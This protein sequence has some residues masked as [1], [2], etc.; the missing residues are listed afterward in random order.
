MILT[1]VEGPIEDNNYLIFNEDTKN[2]ILIDCTNPS[3]DIDDTIKKNGLNLQ[4]ILLTHGHFDHVLGV[5]YYRQKYGA[6]SLIHK[7][8][9]VIIDGINDHMRM[10]GRYANHE[11]PVIDAFLE[12]KIIFDTKEI[13]VLHTPGHTQGSVCFLYENN[14]F[15]GDTLFLESYGR[16]DLPTGSFS[17][18]K[19][20]LEKL[21][22]L[23]ENIKVYPGHG[24]KTSIGYEKKYNAI[25]G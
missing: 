24:E 16:T 17:T 14:L 21:F 22:E 23:D 4:Y 19:Q 10:F 1:F 5:N 8:D 3:K 12:D 25:R 18:I 20:S 6:K 7:D 15:S 13:K 9:K 2:A 11:I